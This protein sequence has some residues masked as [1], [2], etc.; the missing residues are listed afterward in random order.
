MAV[1]GGGHVHPHALHLQKG[2]ELLY[3]GLGLDLLLVEFLHPPLDEG[4]D[5]LHA[6]GQ[7]VALL[8]VGGALAQRQH[9]QLLRQA[10]LRRD[11]LGAEHARPQVVPDEHGVQQRAVHVKNGALQSHGICLAFQTFAT[12]VAPW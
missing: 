3:A 12:I 10:L 7:G 6:L 11:A 2:E 4:D 9:L 8:A 5:L 1:R